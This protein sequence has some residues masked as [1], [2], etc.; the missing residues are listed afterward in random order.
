[1]NRFRRTLTR[2]EKTP[3][4]DG[5]LLCFSCGLIVWN[6]VLLRQALRQSQN[7]LMTTLT[8]CGFQ[9][10]IKTFSLT[11]T[12]SYESYLSDGGNFGSFSVGPIFRQDD[13]VVFIAP[14]VNNAH[15][16]SYKIRQKRENCFVPECGLK[17]QLR[18]VR[19][20]VSFPLLQGSI[21]FIYDRT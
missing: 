15:L 10:A 9:L 2:R 11:M 17:I 5:G 19:P 16:L 6:N 21:E 18:K 7:L 20:L 3:E 13:A 1:M 14:S 8:G 4:N 12:C